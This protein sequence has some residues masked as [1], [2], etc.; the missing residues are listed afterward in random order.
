M[1]T[2]KLFVFSPA[3]IL[4]VLI[5]QTAVSAQA[6]KPDTRYEQ[7]KILKLKGEDAALKDNKWSSESVLYE[8]FYPIGWSKDGK[9]AYFTEPADEACGCYFANLIIQDMRTDKIVWSD[10]YNGDAERQTNDMAETFTINTY[11]KKNQEKFSR[12][13]AQYGIIAQKDF[14]LNY[15]SL[16]S[17]N[18]VFTPMLEVANMKNESD[19][20]TIGGDVTLNM[21]SNKKGSKILY[22]KVFQPKEYSGFQGAEIGGILKSPYESRVAVIVVESYRGYEGPPSITR[23]KIVGSDLTTGFR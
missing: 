10:I 6:V 7:P 22:K 20:F 11:W 3:L 9:F 23:K 13:L 8:A 14:T 16:K 1:M 5:G 4:W 2:K 19:D 17:R 15:S 12:K 21:K 18:D